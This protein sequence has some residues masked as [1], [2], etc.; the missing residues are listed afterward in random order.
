MCAKSGKV[1]ELVMVGCKM[2]KCS[3]LCLREVQ[4]GAYR[5]LD[6]EAVYDKQ[7]F[8]NR[9]QIYAHKFVREN[10]KGHVQ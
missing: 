3:V 4:L 7:Y 6:E 1:L 9:Y 10:L 2:I 5:S 8:Q